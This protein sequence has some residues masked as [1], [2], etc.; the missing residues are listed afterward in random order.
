MTAAKFNWTKLH[1]TEN[2]SSVPALHKNWIS[3]GLLYLKPPLPN[4]SFPRFPHS[5]VF[6]LNLFPIKSFILYLVTH[7]SFTLNT[8]FPSHLLPSA[9]VVKTK[10]PQPT[11]YFSATFSHYTD[12]NLYLLVSVPFQYGHLIY[13]HYL[14]TLT[15]GNLSYVS[16]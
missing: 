16:S 2:K 8:V 9:T 4:L 14:F 10:N 11:F 15:F 7:D 12:P 3:N 13:L 1:V 6:S 5:T